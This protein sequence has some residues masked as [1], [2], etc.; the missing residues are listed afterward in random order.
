MTWAKVCTSLA[1][2]AM[3]GGLV[4]TQQQQPPKDKAKK[5]KAAGPEAAAAPTYKVEKKPFKIALTVKGTLAAEEIAEISYR[6]H[7]ILPAPA[8]QGPL[9]IR[10]IVDH[11]A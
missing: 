1:I 7:P 11:G 8:S 9:T 5:G 2:I 10:T 4:F 3:L 6:P